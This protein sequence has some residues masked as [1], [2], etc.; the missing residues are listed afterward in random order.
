MGSH[1]IASRLSSEVPENTNNFPQS[2]RDEAGGPGSQKPE[3][4]TESGVS[5]AE[6]E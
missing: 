5:E 2:I 1:L 6:E 4:S 3:V